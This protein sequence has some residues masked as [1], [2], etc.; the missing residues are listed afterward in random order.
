MLKSNEQS[1][2]QMENAET[3]NKASRAINRATKL[4]NAM[5]AVQQY[6]DEQHLGGHQA[7]TN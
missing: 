6:I 4:D 1:K 7:T 2:K 3:L 5:G